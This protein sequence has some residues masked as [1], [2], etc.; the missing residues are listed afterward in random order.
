MSA[1]AFE[2][3]SRDLAALRDVHDQMES[4]YKKTIYDL[5]RLTKQTI[6]PDLN[7]CAQQINLLSNL[8]GTP[9]FQALFILDCL[10]KTRTIEGA[11]CEY[12]VAW[13]RTSALIAATLN[14]LGSEKQFWLY[15]SFEG[16]PRPHEKDEMLND[17]LGLGAID[18][19]QGV[20]TVGDDCVRRE[21]EQVQFPSDRVTICKGWIESST[22]P[23]RSPNRI[24]FCYIDMD[25]YKSTKDVLLL[26][27]ERMPKGGRAILDD[28]NYFSKGPKT[29]V[30]EVM[31]DY[32]GDFALL[33]PYEEKFAILIKQ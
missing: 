20:F 6:L 8:Q 22:L 26:L 18:K 27:R 29:A 9:V 30:D 15:D 17:I 11:I 10:A 3:C 28:Y 19:Y 33:N 31:T 21:I 7:I 4:G 25:F 1:D 24:S 12:G 2:Q 5:V 23:E 14:A 32:P 13:G 16:L